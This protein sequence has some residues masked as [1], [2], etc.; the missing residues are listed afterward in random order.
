MNTETRQSKKK[1]NTNNKMKED[2]MICAEKITGKGKRVNIECPAC[3]FKCCRIC[4][5]TWLLDQLEP[6][7]MSC[8]T[9]W[10]LVKCKELLG[11]GFMNG[12]HRKHVKNVL[13]N[14]EKAR[15]P[16]TMPQVENVMT[17]ERYAVENRATELEI[18][19]LFS[20][21]AKLQK[22]QTD[23][24]YFIDYGHHRGED[25]EKTEKKKFM[26]ACPK[27]DCEGFLSSSWKCGACNVWVCKDCHELIGDSKEE[28]HEC[29]ANILASAQ[30][31]KK[32][33]KPCPSCASSI[34]KISGCDQ[35]WC[36]QCKIAF[37]WNT[38]K[39]VRGHVH[40]PHY[41]DWIKNGGGTAAMPGQAM[42][43]GGI[44][45]AFSVRESL[46]NIK[47]SSENPK[48]KQTWVTD[49]LKLFRNNDRNIQHLMS[50]ANLQLNG[51]K[52]FH[53]NKLYFPSDDG[54]QIENY[55]IG[56]YLRP[57][58]KGEGEV[59]KKYCERYRRSYDI[60]ITDYI[61]TNNTI[62]YLWLVYY[63]VITLH[64]ATSHFANVELER[65]RRRVNNNTDSS[66]L[67]VKYIL[68]RVDEK[69]MKTS[70]LK[71]ERQRNKEMA[72]LDIYEVYSRVCSDALRSICQDENLTV[73]KIKTEYNKCRGINIYCNMELCKYTES[74][75]LVTQEIDFMT[76]WTKTRTGI[77][78][79]QYNNNIGENY[80]RAKILPLSQTKK[81]VFTEE[82]L[83]PVS[84]FDINMCKIFLKQMVNVN[85]YGRRWTRQ[86]RELENG[87]PKYAHH[88]SRRTGYG[89]RTVAGDW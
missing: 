42:P 5:E 13:F 35:M 80:W 45:P 49:V 62:K 1:I 32:E 53:N 14:I 86:D 69:K 56:G 57:Y 38:G 77:G 83:T 73:E 20:K 79:H 18:Q 66:D 4:V 12:K 85:R 28:A 82:K 70:L 59:V 22:L 8:K 65:Q 41:Y 55:E 64:Q 75:G 31:L 61:S 39:K 25:Y 3:D 60:N 6:C 46:C 67:R 51:T 72:I 10:T 27:N 71:R 16:E 17:K 23:K 9:K 52:W 63:K 81:A 88:P 37:S 43:C 58:P 47:V 36:T 15:F 33:T 2:C 29:D 26:R 68:K 89:G 48:N 50:T 24:K 30:L 78:V 76:G 40:N 11:K 7:C 34:F 54:R 74:F 44:P 21:V 19:K 84:V 87:N